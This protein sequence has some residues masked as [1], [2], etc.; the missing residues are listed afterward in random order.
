M[1]RRGGQRHGPSR[2]AW[3]LGAL[4]SGSAMRDTPGTD[5]K[6]LDLGKGKGSVCFHNSI[7]LRRIKARPKNSPAVFALSAD[8]CVVLVANLIF[9]PGN[10][11]L[12]I[13]WGG[14]DASPSPWLGARDPGQAVWRLASLKGDT[15]E[16]GANIWTHP[17]WR[18][19][20]G[21]LPP[22]S[23]NL[24]PWQHLLSCPS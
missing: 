8:R 5:S 9:S 20:L 24:D 13:A 1:G 17:Y 19:C 14:Q 4:L 23:C 18:W 11:P 6:G 2:E 3:G 12:P 22:D 15:V 7:M 21:R 10:S 16:S